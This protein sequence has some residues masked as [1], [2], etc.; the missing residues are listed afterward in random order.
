MGN[1]GAIHLLQLRESFDREQS[2]AL[3]LKVLFSRRLALAAQV[4]KNGEELH[5]VLISV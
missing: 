3:K 2:S 4:D 1:N 5:Y